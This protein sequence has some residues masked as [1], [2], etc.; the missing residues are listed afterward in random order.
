MLNQIR[1]PTTTEQQQFIKEMLIWDFQ[2]NKF[3]T[4]PI[5][6][7]QFFAAKSLLGFCL[8]FCVFFKETSLLVV[9]GFFY[10]GK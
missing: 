7:S 10:I 3:F 9:L 2:L 4:E 5:L 8:V 1:T 6:C